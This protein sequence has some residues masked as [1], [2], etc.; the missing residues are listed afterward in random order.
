M[1][2]VCV[3]LQVDPWVTKNGVLP[4]LPEVQGCILIEVT[5]EEVQNVVKHVPKLDTLV[6][7]NSSLSCK[8]SFGNLILLVFIF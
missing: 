7:Y 4:V 3:C 1:Y 6:S 5:E 2:M 8:I